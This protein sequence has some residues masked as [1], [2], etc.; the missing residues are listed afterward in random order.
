MFDAD[1]TVGVPGKGGAPGA[2]PGL[3]IGKA[4][5]AGR[6]IGGLGFPDDDPVF[7]VDIP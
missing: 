1:R 4:L 3:M 2:T 5:P 7:N 6:I